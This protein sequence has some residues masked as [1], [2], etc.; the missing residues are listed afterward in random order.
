LFVTHFAYYYEDHQLLS[1]ISLPL[2]IIAGLA[3]SDPTTTKESIITM[4]RRRTGRSSRRDRYGIEEMEAKVDD[5]DVASAPYQLATDD[6]DIAPVTGAPRDPTPTSAEH[7]NEEN[8]QESSL[9]KLGRLGKKSNEDAVPDEEEPLSPQNHQEVFN[10]EPESRQS[11]D[12]DDDDDDSLEG[13]DMT[14]QELMYST[15]SFYAIVVPGTCQQQ[16]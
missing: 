7:K 9:W 2:L 11:E 16:S 10:D 5:T 12:D 8:G 4:S 13:Y 1:K 14:L 6:G 15:S 3:R